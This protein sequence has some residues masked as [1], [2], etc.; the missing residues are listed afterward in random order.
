[1]V[2]FVAMTLCVFPVALADTLRQGKFEITYESRDAAYATE[3]LTLLA[4]AADEF[5]MRLPMGNAPVF[6]HICSTHAAFS[7]F[8]GP[9][10]EPAVAAVALPEASIIAV[11]TR[12]LIGGPS[13]FD[14]TLRHEF[15]H[16]LIHRNFAPGSIPRWLNEGICMMLAR[17]QRWNAAY[18]LGMMYWYNRLLPLN[19][20]ELAF[21]EP[22]KE[23]AFG[24]AYAQALSMTE[25]L[26]NQLGDDTFW[27]M[28]KDLETT[29]FDMSLLRHGNLTLAQFYE[30]W[31]ATL[32]GFA[33]LLSIVSGFSVFHLMVILAVFAYIRK[34]RKGRRLLAAWRE[35]E[36]E[37][38]AIRLPW[39]Y[40]TASEDEPWRADDDDR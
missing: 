35:E 13:D 23:M 27:A 37:P 29:P 18:Q 20:L 9:F 32:R 21:L 6:V 1:M 22:G 33:V 39:D 40:E 26:H 8:A 30:D 3:A 15:V 31:R 34:R 14:G 24:D 17:E 5:A 19:S 10:A 12:D 4:E 38:E 16:V 25:F 7:K 36:A 2:W 11:K 28:V